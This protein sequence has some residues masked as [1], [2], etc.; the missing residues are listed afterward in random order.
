[1]LNAQYIHDLAYI[2]VFRYR[3][4]K[5][6]I[7]IVGPLVLSLYE[8]LVPKCYSLFTHTFMLVLWN[9]N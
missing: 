2:Q 3:R 1:M 9:E 5:G 7:G 4:S 6:Y 8:C